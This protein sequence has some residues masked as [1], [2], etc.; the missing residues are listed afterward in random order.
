MQIYIVDANN[1]AVP[2]T[3]VVTIE[4]YGDCMGAFAPWQIEWVAISVVFSSR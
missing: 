4:S 3:P 1:V 2:A